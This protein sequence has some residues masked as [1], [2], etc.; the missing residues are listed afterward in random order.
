MST[1]IRKLAILLATLVFTVTS[2]G[3]A[4][5]QFFDPDGGFGTINTSTGNFIGY[6]EW[7]EQCSGLAWECN[8]A[9]LYPDVMEQMLNPPPGHSIWSTIEFGPLNTFVCSGEE[10][11]LPPGFV[12]ASTTNPRVPFMVS[13][14]TGLFQLTPWYVDSI[15]QENDD[16]DWGGFWSTLGFIG[17]GSVGGANMAEFQAWTLPAGAGLAIL[18]N[19][20]Q[21]YAEGWEA[22]GC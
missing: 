21:P 19:G 11:L 14:E 15:E 18:I 22:P 7:M 4:N 17:I 5:A 13:T 6:E 20:P 10:Y 8:W 16:Y 2:F 9:W 1:Y 3:T 12:V